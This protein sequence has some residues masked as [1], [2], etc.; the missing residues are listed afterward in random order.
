V[1]IRSDSPSV[2]RSAQSERDRHTMSE[3]GHLPASGIWPERQ[4]RNT[5]THRKGSVSEE[6]S[7]LHSPLN[8]LRPVE[9]QPARPYSTQSSLTADVALISQ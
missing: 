5:P 1:P 7:S 4:L 2:C 3:V 9:L 8:G 6:F